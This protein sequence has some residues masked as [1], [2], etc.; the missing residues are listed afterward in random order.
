MNS[1]KEPFVE[2][3]VS[4]AS[5]ETNVQ[6]GLREIVASI[7][8]PAAPSPPG[9]DIGRSYLGASHT[10][11]YGGDL[12]DV[13][14]FGDGCTSLVAA[15]VAAHGVQAALH[16]GLVKYA[17]RAYAA[18]GL[19][20]LKAVQALNHLCIAN[21]RYEG[22]D[23]FFASLFFGIV[24]SRRRNL[25]YVS[26]GHASASLVGSSR[27]TALG[28]RGPVIGLIDDEL[29][30]TTRTFELAAGDVIAVV[31]GGYTEARNS[32]R[33]FLGS[34]ALGH[35]VL[36]DPDRN[37]QRSAEAITRR[38]FDLTKQRRDDEVAA[39]VVKI[40]DNETDEPPPMPNLRRALRTRSQ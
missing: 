40:V 12:I 28:A 37:A 30:F 23:N 14:H 17:L 24:D 3:R 13:F 18:Q 29:A 27:V 6:H 22:E 2:R 9:L 7:Y 38:A 4:R 32:E 36:E 34:E 31:T 35:V 8:G 11:N 10:F 21:S 19:T 5:I 25:T 33:D 26:A 1:Q 20:A 16:A 15:D 39:L